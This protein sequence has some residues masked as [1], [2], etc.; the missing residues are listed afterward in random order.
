MHTANSPAQETRQLGMVWQMISDH[1]G[2]LDIVHD[3]SLDRET[4]HFH[5]ACLQQLCDAE[6]YLEGPDTFW[7]VLADAVNLTIAR[8]NGV[9]VLCAGDADTGG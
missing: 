8:V 4:V 9:G 3:W 1:S 7:A 2:C 5:N 6:R